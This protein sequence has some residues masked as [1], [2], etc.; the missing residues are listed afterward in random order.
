MRSSGKV[1]HSARPVNISG[2]RLK[3]YLV[4]PWASQRRWFSYL[5]GSAHCWKSWRGQLLH[6]ACHRIPKALAARHPDLEQD[7]PQT[8]TELLPRPSDLAVTG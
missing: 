7:D 1:P 4:L 3:L 8:E 5:S 6:Q 2:C